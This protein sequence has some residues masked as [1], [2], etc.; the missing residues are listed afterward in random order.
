MFYSDLPTYFSQAA[1]S[2][3]SLISY[4]GDFMPYIEP[5]GWNTDYWT[6]FYTS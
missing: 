2:P 6:G 3:S 5:L 1:K 4:H